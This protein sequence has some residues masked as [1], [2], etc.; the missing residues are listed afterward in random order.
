MWIGALIHR[1]GRS[2]ITKAHKSA[3]WI[4]ERQDHMRKQLG[5]LGNAIFIW[6]EDTYEMLVWIVSSCFWVNCE[7]MS[8]EGRLFVCEFM[9][10]GELWV[11]VYWRKVVCLWVHVF[12]WIVS[13]CLLKEGCLFVCLSH[14][15]L[16]NS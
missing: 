12:G 8:I 4:G 14:W 15:D 16:P 5:K 3:N 6:W 13:S 11:H 9:F 1:S 7:F 2:N 10:L